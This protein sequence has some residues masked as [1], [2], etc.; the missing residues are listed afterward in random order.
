MLIVCPSCASQYTI[1]PGRVGTT[2]RVVRCAACR[3]P[4]FIAGTGAEDGAP[5]RIE[6]P[7]RSSAAPEKGPSSP[8]RAPSR[9]GAPRPRGPLAAQMACIG[10]LA[11]LTAG[12][13]FRTE[14]VRLVPRS[15]SLFA[16]VGLPVNLVGLDIAEARSQLSQGPTGRILTVT[17]AIANPTAH[18]RAVP[19]L[20]LSIGRA[21]GESLY[22]WTAA[23]AAAELAP[24]ATTR[25][26]AKLPSPPPEGRVVVV[27]FSTAATSAKVASR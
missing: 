20:A 13:A 15:A 5:A 9:P 12:L 8:G 11:G 1:E 4:W 7:T 24:G 19:R 26:E 21:D 23:A 16:T 25:F 2:G 6:P 17:A 22:D 3:E 14:V 10:L 27:T 18:A